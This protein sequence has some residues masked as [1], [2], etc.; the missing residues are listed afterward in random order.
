MGNYDE[1]DIFNYEDLM[2]KI[3][4]NNL[5]WL[6]LFFCLSITW[7]QS[8]IAVEKNSNYIKPILMSLESSLPNYKGHNC[9]DGYEDILNNLRDD[10]DGVPPKI[11]KD[12]I[13]GCLMQSAKTQYPPLI[14]ATS[15][16]NDESISAVIKGIEIASSRLGNYGPYHV[17][18]VGNNEEKGYVVD[19]EEIARAYC[20]SSDKYTEEP[21]ENCINNAMNDF[22]NFGC[23]GA[24]HNPSHGIGQTIRYQSAV[25]SEDNR[26]TKEGR[27]I[28]TSA[29][30]YI[31]VFQN[32]F[33]LWGNDIDAEQAGLTEKYSHGPVWL[34][35]GFAEGL[36]QKF[37]YQDGYND[38]YK[39]FLNGA[40]DAAIKVNKTHKFTLRDIATRQDQASVR[41]M[42]EECQGWLQY[43]TAA[44]AL[45]VLESQKG[46]EN[47]MDSFKSYYKSV[48]IV[49]WESAF[50]ISFGMSIDEFYT[51]IDVFMEK[52]KKEQKK[53]I[54]KLL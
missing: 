10:Q 19:V 2:Y 50:K 53:I 4:K 39:D 23:C 9:W 7:P 18:L 5:I 28:I 38:H 1:H 12:K 27:S 16:F 13:A 20:S 34:E 43:E 15:A 26:S 51:M 40:L 45:A 14:F 47:F 46:L 21:F 29:H 8:S 24:A 35:E 31:H 41:S 52:P 54:H 30:E 48:P 33:F 22:P 36:A 17:Y 3:K 6:I 44:I 37:T 49:G 25:F 32:G 42:C 11:D